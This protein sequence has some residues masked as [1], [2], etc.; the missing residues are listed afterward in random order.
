[1]SK[2]EG[3]QESP[4][5]YLEFQGTLKVAF[6][7]EYWAALSISSTVILFF[8]DVGSWAI[9]PGAIGMI[10]QLYVLIV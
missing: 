6:I 8:F 9:T 4:V 5:C 2:V 3:A 1:M 10:A 7:S